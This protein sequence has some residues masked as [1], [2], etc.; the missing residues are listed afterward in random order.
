MGYLTLPMPKG[1]GFKAHSGNLCDGT[2]IF[3]IV[4]AHFFIQKIMR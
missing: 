4:S 2:K 3:K 1:R